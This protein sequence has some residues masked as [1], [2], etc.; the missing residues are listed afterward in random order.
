MM[1]ADQ[2][3]NP[4]LAGLAILV[5]IA[6]MVIAGCS[7][8][9]T[10]Y[11]GQT[12]AI[13]ETQAAQAV[14]TMSTTQTIPVQASRPSPAIIPADTSNPS[15]RAIPNGI[16]MDGI[17]D[18]TA[19]DPLVVSGRTGLPAGTDLIVIVTPSTRVSGKIT[20]NF[21]NSKLSTTIK[22]NGSSANDNRFSVTL[23]TGKLEPAEYILFVSDKND[24]PAEVTA[25]PVGVTGSV[26]FNIIGG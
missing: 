26:L 4:V 17:R 12:S 22:V 24:E 20:G 9:P 7:D 1:D 19:G 8:S 3:S 16:L 15:E 25:E 13:P 14:S 10:S 23:E 18:I 11:Q 6:A 21:Q 5:T 2:K